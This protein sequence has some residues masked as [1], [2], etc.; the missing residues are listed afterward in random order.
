MNVKLLNKKQIKWAV[1][2]TVY[3]FVILYYSKK[4]NSADALLRQSDY[5]KKKQMMNHF[6]SSLQ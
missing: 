6:L 5:Q 1:K 4:N 2:L 3:N